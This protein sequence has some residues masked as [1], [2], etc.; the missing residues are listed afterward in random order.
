MGSLFQSEIVRCAKLH[1]EHIAH[2]YGF[3]RVKNGV[4][5][6]IMEVLQGSLS[7]VLLAAQSCGQYLTLREQLDITQDCLEGLNY[8]HQLVSIH[9]HMV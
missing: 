4:T 6:A 1:H 7:D 8:L 9:V 5:I 3:N 2:V